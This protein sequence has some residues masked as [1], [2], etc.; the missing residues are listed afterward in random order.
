MCIERLTYLKA[1]F[2]LEE[3]GTNVRFKLYSFYIMLTSLTVQYRGLPC[4]P[5]DLVV[6]ATTQS[7]P[8]TILI[9]D[10]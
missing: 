6:L 10:S 4:M 1:V 9:H 7:P 8:F 5:T 3:I 2:M